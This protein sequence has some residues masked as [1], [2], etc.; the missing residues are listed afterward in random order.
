MTVRR[1]T[2][3][4]AA[5]TLTAV[6]AQ[7]IISSAAQAQAAAQ[8]PGFVQNAG[9]LQA[10]SARG[11]N[12]GLGPFKTLTIRGVMLIDGTGAPPTGPVNIVIEG[13]RIARIT[14]AGTP[15]VNPGARQ[16][17]GGA[18][19]RGQQAPPAG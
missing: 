13:N 6:T 18:A 19:G 7:Q 17:G 1:L 2:L 15:G 16:G 8:A 3:L 5:L 14:S 9:G 12:D 4:A 10:A 11:A